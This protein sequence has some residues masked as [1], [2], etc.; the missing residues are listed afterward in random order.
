MSGAVTNTP[1]LGSAEQAYSDIHNVLNPN[2]P[3]AYAVAYPLGV[4]GIILSIIIVKGLAKVNMKE[5]E[6]KLSSNQRKSGFI[7][8]EV[9]ITNPNVENLS[10]LQFCKRYHLNMVISHILHK[11]GT[12]TVVKSNTPIHT[13]DIIRAVVD[14]ESIPTLELMGKVK[15][16]ESKVQ[17]TESNLISQKIIVT[18]SEWNGVKMDDV[19]SYLQDYGVTITRVS[20]SGVEF[21]AFGEARLVLGDTIE[22]VGE[23]IEVQKI[24][25][26]FGDEI[27]KL[28]APHIVPIFFGIALGVIFG[29]LPISIPG[30]SHPFKLG[31]AGTSLIVA[32]LMGRFGASYGIV[33]FS[34]A[35][36]NMMLRE[37]GLALF[38]ASVGLASGNGFVDAIVNGGYMWLLY[39]L[40]I[41]MLPL[42]IMG[43]IAYKVLR[44]NYLTLMGV[45]AGATTDP[46]ALGYTMSV[47]SG[48]DC[49][50]LGYATVYPLTMF[51]RV[52]MAQ[53]MVLLLC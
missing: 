14:P 35:S 38:L 29:L 9:C 26:L 28:D 31:L 5:E 34:T 2:I 45:M 37:V 30:L 50:S 43:I 1:S 12:E 10:A 51:L 49:P 42:L 40:I 39:G 21:L 25:K 18:R 15:R 46:P 41:T 23:K 17:K 6:Q 36:A 16:V 20:R 48:N 33:T 7:S 8:T 19:L 52:L 3:M 32:L 22:V 13:D 11:D 44:I 53:L 47:A 27:K 4:V 24:V